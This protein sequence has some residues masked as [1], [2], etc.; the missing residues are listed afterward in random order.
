MPRYKG[1]V[2]NTILTTAAAMATLLCLALPAAAATWTTEPVPAGPGALGPARLSFDAQGRALLVWN[3]VPTAS[4]PRFTGMATRAPEGG[5]TRLANLPDV[6]WG[7][8][9]ALQYGATRVLFVSGQVASVGANNR[10]KLRLVAAFG[11]SN[12]S[13]LGSWRTLAPLET[14]FVAAAAPSGQAIVLY[15]A[16]GTGLSTIERP[17]GG[18]F[19]KATRV[20]SAG[21][22]TPA[23]AINARGDRIVAWIRSGRIEARVRSAGRGWGSVLAVAAAPRVANTSLRATVSTGGT[24]LLAW[25]AADVRESSPTRLIAGA[26]QRRPGRGWRSYPLENGVT[27]SILPETAAAFPLVTSTGAIAIVWTGVVGGDAHVGAKAA[28]L[29]STGL[30]PAA[31]VSDPA[32]DAAVADAAVGPTGQAAIVWTQSQS[33]TYAALSPGPGAPFAAPDLLTPPGTTGIPGPAVASDPVT[34]RAIAIV[35]V[36]QDSSGGYVAAVQAP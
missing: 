6:G 5:W 21:A 24:F 8:A 4:Q 33:S 22:S 32:A 28:R 19:S 20:S 25:E 27:E 34:G 31:T 12:G 17:A 10:A 29:T 14:G 13:G 15:D 11:R 16:G 18:S 36:V 2:R 26:A 9:Q 23:V 3:G 1:D 30:R 35:P 7:N